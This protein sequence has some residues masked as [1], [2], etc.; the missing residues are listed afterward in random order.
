MRPFYPTQRALP[1]RQ[2]VGLARAL[3]KLGYCSGSHAWVLIQEGRVRADGAIE[4]N[5]E[6][7]DELGRARIEVDGHPLGVHAK[8]YLMLNKPRGLVTTLSDER[9]RDT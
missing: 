8:I 7:P 3:S 5:P 1:P 6:H 4:R 2:K 9:G